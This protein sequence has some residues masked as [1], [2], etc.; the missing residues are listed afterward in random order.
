MAARKKVGIRD[1]AEAAGVSTTTV[2]YVLNGAEGKR[3]SAE[4]TE[5]VLSAAKR[6]D[7]IPNAAARLLRT[8]APHVVSVRLTATLTIPRYSF[9]LE[10]IRDCLC[11]HA[12][13]LL[14]PG[15]RAEG[16]VPSYIEACIGERANGILYIS[17]AREDIPA[18]ELAQIRRY[19]IPLSAVDCMTEDP[20]IS[21]VAYDYDA[22][23]AFRVTALAQRG[24]RRF[25]LLAPEMEN[26]KIDSRIRT[27]KECAER[28]GL[29]CEIIPVT[30]AAFRGEDPGEGESGY[31][32]RPFNIR[33]VES[34]HAPELGDFIRKLRGIVNA[35]PADTAILCTFPAMQDLVTRMLYT[36]HRLGQQEGS[37][38]W[39]LLSM[40]YAFPHYEIGYEAARSLLDAIA[41]AP[42][43]KLS[44]QP[45]II[46][47]DPE[48]FA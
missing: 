9:L 23:S 7:Y 18:A 1:I 42:P 38:P 19:G 27:F 3:I 2:S 12:Y 16:N 36:R 45:R 13:D 25:V 14:M 33:Y 28:L 17:S 44:F 32:D 35:V 10:G 4:T 40:S 15:E 8:G 31:F 21:S 24:V 37:V 46:P 48:L 20:E 22:T 11:E 41:G 43:R 26:V 29:A 34:M 47:V 39:H 6:L 30:P 5:R